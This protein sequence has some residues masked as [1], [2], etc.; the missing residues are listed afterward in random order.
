MCKR[1]GKKFRAKISEIKVIFAYDLSGRIDTRF[2]SGAVKDYVNIPIIIDKNNYI[3]DGHHRYWYLKN[4]GVEEIPVIQLD[5]TFE[6]SKPWRMA[7]VNIKKFSKM[8]NSPE[9][10]EEFKKLTLWLT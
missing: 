1:G 9:L 3:I 7:D 4:R 6:E 8:I 5:M 2:A 10:Y